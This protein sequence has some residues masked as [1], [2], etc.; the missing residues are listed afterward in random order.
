[1]SDT[2]IEDAPLAESGLRSR[3][4]AVTL[5]Q[6][7]AAAERVLQQ[8]E[9]RSREDVSVRAV[10]AALGRHGSFETIGRALRVWKA[11][12]QP[13]AEPRIDL[14]PEDEARIREFA[15]LMLSVITERSQSLHQKTVDELTKAAE[16]SEREVARVLA[17]MQEQEDELDAAREKIG[18]LDTDLLSLREKNESLRTA[19]A[20]QADAAETA[21]RDLAQ[22][23]HRVERLEQSLLAERD[24]AARAEGARDHALTELHESRTSFAAER[25]AS[26]VAL[27]QQRAETEAQKQIVQHQREQIATD[28]GVMQVI[29]GDLMSELEARKRAEKLAEAANTTLATERARHEERQQQIVH[30]ERRV[31]ELE[32]QK[33][34]P[35]K[36]RPAQ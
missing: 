6:I 18:S 33:V 13:K 7:T 19:M 28:A 12:G 24:R 4:T 26:N 8:I 32:A 9:S 1:M 20:V 31:K 36:G 25:E 22:E 21:R 16:Q 15:V 3:R 23:R 35:Q 10:H 14:L 11:G 29:N 2:T 34:R 27:D 5:D 30:L 17:E